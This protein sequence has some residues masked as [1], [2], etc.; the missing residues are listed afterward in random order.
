MTS[1]NKKPCIDHRLKVRIDACARAASCF[2][3]ILR[4]GRAN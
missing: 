4:G 1:N 3:E 2:G